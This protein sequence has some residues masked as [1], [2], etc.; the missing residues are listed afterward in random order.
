MLLK[1]S[2]NPAKI[3]S[4]N[5]PIANSTRDN[6]AALFPRPNATEAT[7]ITIVKRSRLNLG[8]GETSSGNCELH[9]EV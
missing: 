1:G 6:S 4:K 9:S 5:I 7:A 3:A 2:K 8:L